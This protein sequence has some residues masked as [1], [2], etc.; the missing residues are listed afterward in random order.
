MNIDIL[1]ENFTKLNIGI[2]RDS[3]RNGAILGDIYRIGN[4]W[5]VKKRGYF[6]KDISS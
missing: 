1:N 3:Q 2:V 4:K 5:A 6:A